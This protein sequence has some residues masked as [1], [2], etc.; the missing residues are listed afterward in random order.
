MNVACSKPMLGT[1]QRQPTACVFL[2]RHAV[3]IVKSAEEQMEGDICRAP[4]QVW[5]KH[6]E[7]DSVWRTFKASEGWSEGNKLLIADS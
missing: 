2:E 1:T 5:S 3:T 6:T 7:C 4:H